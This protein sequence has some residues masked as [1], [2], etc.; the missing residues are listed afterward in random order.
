MLG[1]LGVVLPCIVYALAGIY[2]HHIQNSALSQAT[3]IAGI[4]NSIAVATLIALSLLLVPVA[5]QNV[6]FETLWGYHDPAAVVKIH[7]WNG[8]LVMLGVVLHG[9]L[10]LLQ[11][12][13]LQE[14]VISMLFPSLSCFQISPCGNNNKQQCEC[15]D[16]VRN[17]LGLVAAISLSI[18]F[19]SSCEVVRRR[20]YTVFYKIHILAVPTMLFCTMLHWK[21]SII[22]MSGGLLY[23]TA[24]SF[25][26]IIEKLLQCWKRESN[27]SISSVKVLSDN[28][29]LGHNSC[30]AVTIAASDASIFQYQPGQYVFLKAPNVSEISHPF[31]INICPNKPGFMNIIL[32]CSGHFTT[33]VARQL[34]NAESQSLDIS[35]VTAVNAENPTMDA[36][37]VTAP[38]LFMDG[39]YGSTRRMEKI[40]QHDVIVI[41]AGGVGVTSYLSFLFN[42]V[43]T[44]N[45]E[46]LTKVVFHWLCRDESLIRYVENEFFLPILKL[47]GEMKNHIRLSIVIHRTRKNT[48]PTASLYSETA[49][50]SD[51]LSGSAEHQNGIPWKANR[52]S[53][54]SALSQISII[55]LGLFGVVYVLSKFLS[56]DAILPRLWGPLWIT[57]LS[58]GIS[59]FAVLFSNSGRHCG[60]DNNIEWEPIRISEDCTE[61]SV[62]LGN[63]KE[64]E[65]I[66]KLPSVLAEEG[67][68][69]VE[70]REGRPSIHQFINA[71]D[72]ARWP[73]LF[74]CG[75]VPLMN[76]VRRAVSARCDIRCR[77]CRGE[78]NIVLYQEN[79]EM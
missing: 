8:R 47:Y 4:S 58:V 10:Y 44:R 37:P 25:P 27:V 29:I 32:R 71:L 17:F 55:W 77:Q 3:K 5:R 6:L 57:A 36:C 53:L 14:N 38:K 65:S 66:S 40:L 31:S 67:P 72:E 39:F 24:C 46:N 45:N 21:K 28:G 23:Y 16:L 49:G 42:I 51:C 7:I 52:M 18:L 22:Y 50:R 48:I 15:Y 9:S 74:V 34:V 68:L 54:V 33:S 62:E 64:G 56:G 26:N 43:Q 13:V 1:I 19:L 61:S 78:P 73:G 41:V 12:K 11:W 30:V 70:E 75:P 2:R 76:D 60:C 79:F 69:I 59:C 35:P 20:M 63:M